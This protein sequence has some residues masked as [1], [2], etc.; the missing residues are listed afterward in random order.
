MRI[1][2]LR[3]HH[4]GCF[5][6]Y[7]VDLSKG[8]NLIVGANG[9]GKTTICSAVSWVLWGKHLRDVKGEPAVLAAA[10]TPDGKS[11][12]IRR[13][14]KNQSESVKLGGG[15]PVNKTRFAESMQ[16]LLGDWSSWCRSL[17][18]TGENVAT[19]SRGS[20]SEKFRLL[21]K[22]VDADRYDRMIATLKIKIANATDKEARAIR[23]LESNIEGICEDIGEYGRELDK[24]TR[25]YE[26]NITTVK[27]EQQTELTELTAIRD[28]LVTELAELAATAKE[29]GAEETELSNSIKAV[30]ES[31]APC[32]SCGQRVRP[33]NEKTE[34]LRKQLQSVVN[35]LVELRKKYALANGELREVTRSMER[36]NSR[37]HVYRRMEEMRHDA[38]LTYDGTIPDLLSAHHRNMAELNELKTSEPPST[39]LKELL[40]LVVKTKQDY[41]ASAAKAIAK[42]ANNY[43]SVISN[44]MVVDLEYKDGYLDVILT[45]GPAKAYHSLSSGQKRRVDICLVIAMSQIA[46]EAGTVPKSAPMIIDEAFDTLD[47]AGVEAL[48]SLACEISKQRQV[49]LVSHADPSVPLGPS[50]SKICL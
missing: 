19:F 41:L 36:V 38:E 46:A 9:S 45:Q 29:L 47:S 18:I 20:P 40:D 13:V 48:I 16:P 5:P 23:S 15:A 1:T 7:Q 22:L 27:A 6:Q 37:S 30:V 25:Q 28:R 43:L 11:T 3:L 32:S 17:W 44:G 24:A 4:Y 2:S 50:V 42:T 14:V 49:F 31:T 8:V 39:A 12:E 33:D 21:S 10:L 35:R 34:P 26:Y